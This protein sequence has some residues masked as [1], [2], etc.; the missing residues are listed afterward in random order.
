MTPRTRSVSRLLEESSGADLLELLQ[1]LADELERR[2]GV[3]P[4]PPTSAEPESNGLPKLYTARQ[5]A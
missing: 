1:A 5:A 4:V 3:A 2:A